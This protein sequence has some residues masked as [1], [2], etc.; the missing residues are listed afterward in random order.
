MTAVLGSD[1]GSHFLTGEINFR[2]SVHLFGPFRIIPIFATAHALAA[3]EYSLSLAILTRS[4]VGAFSI[5]A[6]PAITKRFIR[7]CT[8]TVR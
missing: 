7:P 6:A 4:H 1:K 2:V 8:I 5:K 3:L